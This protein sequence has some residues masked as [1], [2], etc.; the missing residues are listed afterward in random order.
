MWTAE[1]WY[2]AAIKAVPGAETAAE[3]EEAA[4]AATGEFPVVFMTLLLVL[5]GEAVATW[6]KLELAILSSVVSSCVLGF[7]KQESRFT[8]YSS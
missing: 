7:I 6:D 8:P 4:V 3:I 2:A 1:F 5:V